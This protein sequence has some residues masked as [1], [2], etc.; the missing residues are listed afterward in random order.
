MIKTITYYKGEIITLLV[1]ILYLYFDLSQYLTLPISISLFI[2]TAG[3]DLY[4]NNKHQ[5]PKKEILLLSTN[6]D[7]ENKTGKLIFGSA[8]LLAALGFLFFSDFEIINSFLG[9]ILGVISIINSRYKAKSLFIKISGNTFKYKMGKI[10]K[11]YPIEDILEVSI[12]N[13]KIVLTIKENIIHTISFLHLEENE[14]KDTKRFFTTHLK[15]NDQLIR[16]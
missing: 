3:Y 5:T 9:I 11:D 8:I 2:A 7:F 10:E 15:N 6:N 12:S 1:I 16:N 13:K 4:I 14:I